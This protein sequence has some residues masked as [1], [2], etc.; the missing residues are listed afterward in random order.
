MKKTLLMFVI[1]SCASFVANAQDV[2]IGS[3][4][5]VLQEQK[6]NGEKMINWG[7]YV[8][9]LED[10]IKHN[11]NPPKDTNYKEVV[12][13]F[14]IL[15]DGTLFGTKI[16]KSS[17]T[18]LVDNA[19]IEAIQKTSPYQPLPEQFERESLPIEYT[20]STNALTYMCTKDTCKNQY[21]KYYPEQ[22]KTKFCKFIFEHQ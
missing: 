13:R 5:I 11:W 3:N 14:V 6:N 16:I 2:V 20:F 17:G 22:C 19:A 10:N 8:K 18:L 4:E 12:V 15:K 1:L 21:N 9:K 7:P